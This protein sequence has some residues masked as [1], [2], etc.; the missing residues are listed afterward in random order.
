MEITYDQFKAEVQPADKVL[1]LLSGG[2]DS[3]GM[4]YRILSENK[5]RVYV[6]HV[7]M[8]NRERR[9]EAESKA[10]KKT[11]KILQD[12]GYKFHYHETS[13]SF[14]RKGFIGFDVDIVWFLAAQFCI[15]EKQV[16][17]VMS[18]RNKDDGERNTAAARG[19]RCTDLFHKGMEDIVKEQPKTVR[20]VIDLYKKEIVDMLPPQLV[21]SS[22]SCRT[23]RN[24]GGVFERCGRC[25][26]CKEI[27]KQ[28]LW[29]KLPNRI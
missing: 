2:V 27:K 8:E 19:A 29:D 28:E 7:N 14:N 16:K 9:H 3:V 4:L 25:I 18:G 26:T 24:K 22:W 17:Y 23:P 1:I 21:Q 11:V 5:C 6:Y 15:G 13:F 10:V 20:P 12:M